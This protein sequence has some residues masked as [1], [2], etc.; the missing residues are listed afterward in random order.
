MLKILGMGKEQLLDLH[1]DSLKKPGESE[2]VLTE[3]ETI[4]IAT[5]LGAFWAYN[6][7]ALK[8]GRPGLHAELKSGLHSDGFFYSK[9]LLESWNMRAVMADQIAIHFRRLGLAKPDWAAG[10]PDGA[11]E[12]G[13]EV[14]RILETKEAEM[15]KE[16]GKIILVSSIEAEETLLLNEDFCTQGTGFREAVRD[17]LSRQPQTK[18]LPVEMVL[19]NRGGLKEIEI[20]GVGTFKIVS[21]VEHR[22]Q[23]WRPPDCPLCQAGSKAIKPKATD[24]N[25]RLITTS[26]L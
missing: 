12:L 4:Y 11:T 20:E 26:Q 2:R 8:E 19:I 21:I 25:W 1:P 22:V 24:E 7:Q 3:E 6:Y 14:A 23:D 17:I 9:I 18:I 13:R 5:T 15:K 10:I 16:E